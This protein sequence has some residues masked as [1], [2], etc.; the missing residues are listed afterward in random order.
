[1]IRVRRLR[2]AVSSPS[3][4]DSRQ[5]FEVFRIKP[6]EGPLEIELSPLDSDTKTLEV[7]AVFYW[8]EKSGRG[9]CRIG[10]QGWRIPVEVSEGGESTLVLEH[11][12]GR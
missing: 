4:G 1:E 11:T 8:C 2:Q 7:V 9:L 10:I 3:S 5:G 6:Q 12:V